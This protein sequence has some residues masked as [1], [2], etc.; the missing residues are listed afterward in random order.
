M[1]ASLLAH[2]GLPERSWLVRANVLGSAYPD[3]NRDRGQI[4]G[5][6]RQIL[7]EADAGSGDMRNNRLD[8]T[9]QNRAAQRRPWLPAREDDER[10]GNPAT[11]AGHS[12]DP[13]FD[14]DDR[15]IGAG[16]SEQRRAEN[17][18]QYPVQRHADS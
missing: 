13:K 7:R 16:Q 14:A 11:A 6:Q 15:N 2:V 3:H 12:G 18:R 1:S 9:E 8:A 4:G 5:H 17:D 10:Y